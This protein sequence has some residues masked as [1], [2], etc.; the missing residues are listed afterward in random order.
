MMSSIVKM[1]EK[2]IDMKGRHLLSPKQVYTQQLL[3]S[4][5]L[6]DKLC[7]KCYDAVIR[8]LSIMD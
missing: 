7:I 5:M 2:F 1:N 8:I 3:R 4:F 6:E